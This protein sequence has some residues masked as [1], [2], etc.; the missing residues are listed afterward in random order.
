MSP[1]VNALG[2][3]PGRGLFGLWSV[4]TASP[5]MP[6][7]VLQTA[8]HCPPFRWDH[9]PVWAG[10]DKSSDEFMPEQLDFLAKNRDFSAIE[11]HQA[12]R[13]H[14][15]T[16][17][18]FRVAARQI[19]TW[20]PRGQGT[21]L[22]ERADGHLLRPRPL[23]GRGNLP[24][25]RFPGRRPEP[26][27][28]ATRIRALLR[29]RTAAEPK[30][31]PRARRGRLTPARALGGLSGKGARPAC[32]A[33]R[34]TRPGAFQRGPRPGQHRRV[35]FLGGPPTSPGWAHQDGGCV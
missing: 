26:R 1:M 19:R 11:K 27:H 3:D 32:V 12:G 6:A 18:D 4:Q 28:R 24:G 31:S 16:M 29:R 20:K 10:A 5:R 7:A 35:S 9:V 21:L 25:P 30:V 33:G 34:Q 2:G 14:G 17:E 8:G 13:G 23:P 22:P 15:G